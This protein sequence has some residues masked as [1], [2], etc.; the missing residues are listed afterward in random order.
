MRLGGSTRS[1]INLKV[2]A[3]GIA[4]YR[5]S[6]HLRIYL[7]LAKQPNSPMSFQK[8]LDGTAQIANGTSRIPL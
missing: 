3:L 5:S 4:Y 8:L 1:R 7:E 6:D 2:I